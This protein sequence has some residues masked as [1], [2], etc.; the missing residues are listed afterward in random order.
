M[1]KL[2]IVVSFSFFSMGEDIDREFA[3]FVSKNFSKLT[4]NQ[5]RLCTEMG[6]GAQN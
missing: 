1:N 4:E 2:Y 5:K 3:E 6:L